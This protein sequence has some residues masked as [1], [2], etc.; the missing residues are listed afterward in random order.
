MNVAIQ[1]VPLVMILL[2]VLVCL[3]AHYRDRAHLERDHREACARPAE[4]EKELH[5]WIVSV[6]PLPHPPAPSR[7]PGG[8]PRRVFVMPLRYP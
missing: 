6:E 4:R 7:T 5:P 8:R 2:G 3:N 1:A